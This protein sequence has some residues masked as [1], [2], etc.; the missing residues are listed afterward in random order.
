MGGDPPAS[1]APAPDTAAYRIE[2]REV[3]NSRDREMARDP[4]CGMDV[5]PEAAA[6]MSRYKGVD[7]YFCAVACKEVFD[8]SPE[9]HVDGTP[10]VGLPLMPRTAAPARDLKDRATTRI[11]LPIRGMSCASCVARIESALSKLDGVEEAAVN[12]ATQRATV[13]YDPDRVAPAKLVSE[14]RRSGY[15]VPV[16]EAVLP[17]EGMSCASCAQR[18]ETALLKTPGVLSASVNFAAGRATVSYVAGVS[19][20]ADFRRVIEE[21]G[22]RVPETAR[23]PAWEEAKG[24]AESEEIRLLRTKLLVG[25]ALSLPVLVGS[26]PDWFPWAPTGL[27]NPFLLLLLTTPVQFWVG[28]QFHRGFWATLKH[29]TADMN[30]LVSIG[31]NAAYFYSLALTVFPH[32]I[33]PRG[34]MVM[35]YYDT[36]AILITLIILGRWLEAKAKGRTS[37]AI[38]RLVGLQARTARVIRAGREEDIPIE[39]VRVGDV[40]LVRPG[41]KVPVDG[42]IREGRSALD[43]SMLTGE[44]LPIEKGPGDPVVGATLNKT[45]SFTFEATRVGRETVLAQIVRLVEQAQGSKAPIQRLVDKVAGVFVPI[46]LVIAAVTF[47]VWLLFGPDPSF[48]FALSNVVAVLVIACPCAL[49]LATPTSIMVGTGKGAE[50]G[51][52]IKNADSL[53]R[54]HQVRAIVFDK[55][56]TLTEGRPSVTDIITSATSEVRGAE[57]DESSV[58]PGAA[59]ELLRL[60]ASAEKGSEHPLGEAIVDRAKGEGLQLAAP[61]EFKA[62]PGYGVRAVVERKEILVGNLRLMKEHG[63]EMFGMDGQADALAADGKTPMLVAA[64]R[65]LLGIVA[66]A[67]TLKPHSRDAVTALRRMAIDVAMITG[68]NRR[69]AEAIARQVGIDRVLAEVLPEHKAVEVRKLQEQGDLVAMV[70][71]GINDAPALAQADVGIAIGSG[72]DVAIEAADVTLIGGDLRKVVAAIELS[73]RTMRNIKENLFWA[74]AYNVLLIPVAAGVLYPFFGVLL[75]PVLAGAAMALSSVTVVSNA[76]RLRRVR[77]MLTR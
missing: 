62:I 18:I 22:Y 39:E 73:K 49:G 61:E 16:E 12:L 47:G 50:F 4:I 43:E 20:P 76:L 10:T 27:S 26:F 8:R 19:Q 23:A 72:T 52:L 54:A 2:V 64:D 70:G 46:V 74:F 71:D 75:S 17:I 5:R 24:R 67:D 53:E 45:G 69:T 48:L 55:T 21:A 60:A 42:I 57:S 77:P 31:T 33:S 66:V 34:M 3:D 36:A 51:V 13:G 25:M 68:D 59:R 1:G 14:V 6:G 29:R 40:V 37:E 41:E 58:P 15:E 28:W 65:R 35:P 32:A 38:R 7:Y 63:V 56:G 30:T 11:E 44:S 9:E